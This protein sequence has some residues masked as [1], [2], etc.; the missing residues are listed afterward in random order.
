MM[1]VEYVGPCLEFWLEFD[2]MECVGYVFIYIY[3]QIHANVDDENVISRYLLL[4]QGE[5]SRD[6][7]D[8]YPVQGWRV[9]VKRGVWRVGGVSFV[10][11]CRCVEMFLSHL[12]GC[13]R[14]HP[15]HICAWHVTTCLLL[16][17]YL[18]MFEQIILQ[19]S[20]GWCRQVNICS[21]QTRGE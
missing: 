9:P 21:T 3:I 5:T 18:D 12:C 19:N 11:R 20:V 8:W 14:K 1:A 15:V 7:E 6:G 16:L 4:R 13:M 2:L 10:G 17:M